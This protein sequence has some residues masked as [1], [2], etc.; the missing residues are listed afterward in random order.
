MKKDFLAISAVQE[1][2]AALPLAHKALLLLGTLALM[3]AAFYFLQYKDQ[4]E[5]ID[6]LKQ[7]ISAQEQRLATLK[8]AAAQVEVLQKELAQAEEEFKYLLTFLPDRRE[9]PALLDSVSQ[10]GSQVGLEN[11][12]F[13][14]QPEQPHDFYAAIPVRLD[15]LGTYH[16]LGVFLDN[17]SKLHRILRVENLSTTR[18]RGAGAE[19][20]LQ[21][22]CTIVTYRFLD[23]SDQGGGAPAK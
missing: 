21:V 11:I 8:A 15:L 18:Q 13:Q 20:M 6:K 17:V 19:T 1:K 4:V 7:S 16:E 12:L 10:L 2:L 23:K 3:G 14:P 9:I 22:G 5:A